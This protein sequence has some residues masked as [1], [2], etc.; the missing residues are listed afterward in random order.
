M[1]IAHKILLPLIAVIFSGCQTFEYAEDIIEVSENTIYV[2]NIGF[3]GF[4]L[5]PP[6][7]Y[8]R[9]SDQDLA[10][11]PQTQLWVDSLR[12]SYRNSEGLNYHFHKDFTF[13][14]GE[15]VICFIPFQLKGARQFIHTPPDILERFLIDWARRAEFSKIIDFDLSW[16]AQSDSRGNSTVILKSKKPI[17]GWVY[18]ER[19]MTGDLNEMFIFAGFAKKEDAGTLSYELQRLEAALTVIR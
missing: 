3:K 12:I 17:N 13:K 19:A 2:S 16:N 1:N 18:E 8:Q 11:N 10:M 7:N 6:D 9:L 15:Q 4:K 14:V 5:T